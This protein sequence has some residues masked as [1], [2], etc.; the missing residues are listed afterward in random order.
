MQQ[1]VAPT[2]SNQRKPVC[3]NKDPMQPK[4]KKKKEA[5]EVESISQLQ[6]SKIRHEEVKKF[7]QSHGANKKQSQV[8]KTKQTTKN[9]A[10]KKIWMSPKHRL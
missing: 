2:R 7:T 3:S 6:T 9:Q 1:R 5:S 8:L 10:N 4:K